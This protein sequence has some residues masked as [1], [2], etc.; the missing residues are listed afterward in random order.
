[1]NDAV[2]MRL[3]QGGRCERV[4]HLTLRQCG[5]M[6]EQE[7]FMG[8]TFS[9][10]QLKKTTAEV[11]EKA[12]AKNARLSHMKERNDNY[13]AER[14]DEEGREEDQTKEL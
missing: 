9:E 14:R 3:E 2:A 7:D 5:A 1:L 11:L 8:Q 10:Q 4:L 13:L 12:K 6:Q